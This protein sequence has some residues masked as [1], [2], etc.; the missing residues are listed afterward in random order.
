MAR[1][2]HV[3]AR[4][5]EPYD[6]A[7]APA[8]RPRRPAPRPVPLV[9]LRAGRTT[10]AARA[11]DDA[12]VELAERRARPSERPRRADRGGRAVTPECAPAAAAE[13]RGPA[14]HRHRLAGLRAVVRRQR[15]DQRQG[16]RVGR[17]LRRGRAA[18]LLQDQVELGDGAVQLVVQAGRQG[19]RLRHQPD[20][21]HARARRG[22]R[23]LRRLLLRQPGRDRAGGHRRRRSHDPS[24]DLAAYKLGA[25]TGTTSLT[26]IRD[27]IKPTTSRRSSRT[28]TPPSRRCSTT[29]STRSSPTSRPRSTSP[30][31][32]IKNSVDRRPVPAR[33]RRAGAVRD[34]LR[35][36]QPAG[37]R[38]STRRWRR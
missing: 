9:G 4:S 14:H 3:L 21:D 16:L 30:R 17:R 32:E 7:H 25:Q 27:D 23:L 22:R 12:D 28:P 38:A 29:R 8:Y 1:T 10:A 33:H 34:A 24:A 18:R 19:L 15:P 13:R 5:A 20:L 31:S 26:A 6:L 2:R 37:R 35:E 11:S 36:G